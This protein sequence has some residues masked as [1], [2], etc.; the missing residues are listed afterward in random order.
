MDL[1]CQ[2][3]QLYAPIFIDIFPGLWPPNLFS[4]VLLGNTEREISSNLFMKTCVTED[5][6][7]RK[8]L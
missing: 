1:R 8:V 4:Y 7:S 5:L 2:V 3:G 6:T